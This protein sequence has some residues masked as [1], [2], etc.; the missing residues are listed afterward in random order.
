MSKGEVVSFLAYDEATV[1]RGT[2]LGFSRIADM[3][4]VQLESEC[5]LYIDRAWAESHRLP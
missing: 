5:H 1:I 4:V 2:V 3:V